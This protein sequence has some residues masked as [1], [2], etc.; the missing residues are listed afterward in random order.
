ME[1]TTTL[2]KALYLRMSTYS[3]GSAAYKR[4]WIAARK[5]INAQLKPVVAEEGIEVK[6]AGWARM[7]QGSAHREVTLELS[8]D[9]LGYLGLAYDACQWPE[10]T[11]AMEDALLEL[12]DDLTQWN[13]Q[14]KA[15]EALKKLSPEQR[16]AL[17]KED[18]RAA[19]A[20]KKAKLEGAE[21][22]G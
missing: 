12:S 7:P 8:Q 5:A 15:L 9:D 10:M 18:A 19:R 2:L 3:A 22:G 13:E 1:I 14:A 16:K 17:A 4:Y 6:E 11:E 21:H 20:I